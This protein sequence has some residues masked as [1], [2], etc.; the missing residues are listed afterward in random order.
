VTSLPNIDAALLVLMGISQGGY[1][2]KKLVTTN[3]TT[4]YGVSPSAGEPG[5][6]VGLNGSMFGSSQD[7]SQLTLDGGVVG[8]SDITSWSDKAIGFKVPARDIARDKDWG[9]AQ[10]VS[11]RVIVNGQPTNPQTF[12]VNPPVLSNPAPPA[13][14]KGSTVTIAGT[15]LGDAPG[16]LTINGSMLQ[17]A[18]Q[19]S[20][21]E[22]TLT[23]PDRDP[24]TNK[25]WQP[26]QQAFVEAVVNGHTSNRVSFTVTS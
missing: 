8:E 26:G 24:A 2:G 7:G 4:L 11:V 3:S 6:P 9:V 17:P 1:V 5:D 12:T 20:D 10:D 14:A 16:Q 25:D 18:P 21:T 19:W 13:A 15:N 23:V 22:I